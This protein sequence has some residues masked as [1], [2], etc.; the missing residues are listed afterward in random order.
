MNFHHHFETVVEFKSST[1]AAFDY[2]DD[3]RKLSSHMGKSTWMMAGSKMT[4]EL[5]RTEGRAL[6]SKIIM[7]GKIM[8]IPLYV[9]EDVTERV[10]PLKKSWETRG[11]QRL[12]VIDQYKMGFELTPN[13]DRV[14]LRVFID[15]SLPQNGISRVLGNLFGKVYARWCTETMAQDVAGH[16]ART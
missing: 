16:F 13:V 9:N 10:P 3:P 4:L 5:D 6:G 11:P 12:V 15:Y 2:L 14:K 1:V 8:G 7:K